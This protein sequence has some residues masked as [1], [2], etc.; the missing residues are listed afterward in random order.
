MEYLLFTASIALSMLI[1]I[2][3]CAKFSTGQ[4]NNQ[5]NIADITTQT[6][7]LQR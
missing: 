1:K 2:F 5:Y 3:I 7:S 6:Q 4:P